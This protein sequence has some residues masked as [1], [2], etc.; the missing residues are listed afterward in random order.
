MG[1]I[2]KIHVTISKGYA[3]YKTGSK[4]QPDYILQLAMITLNY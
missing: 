4:L 1:A 3:H 2:Y